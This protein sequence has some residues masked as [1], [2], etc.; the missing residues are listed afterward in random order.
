MHGIE[1][2]V[3]GEIVNTLSDQVMAQSQPRT[4]PDSPA[5]RNFAANPGPQSYIDTRDYGPS[6]GD[7][8]PATGMQYGEY[9]RRYENER[10]GAANKRD[11][12]RN[13]IL[14][15]LR[16]LDPQIQGTILRR[17]GLDAGAIKSQLQ[18]QMELAKFRQQLEAP[19]QAQANTL[20]MLI[21]QMQQGEKMQDRSL[22]ERQLQAETT[23]RA[24]GRDIQLMRALA[25]MMQ[26]DTS[27]KLASTI[28]P[29]LMQMAQARGINL[30]PPQPSAPGAA[31]GGRTGIK[32]TRRE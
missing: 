19:Q 2:L 14:Q 29:W 16:G 4:L 9:A 20:K 22:K 26:G 18:Q 10:V 1:D 21:A 12:V 7:V 31:G 5:N 28:G 11:A 6:R 24:E 8:N 15:N 23:G 17:L 30:S 25:L 27:G 32:I 13:T 3:I